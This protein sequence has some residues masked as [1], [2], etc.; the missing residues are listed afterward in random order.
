MFT[1]EFC[2]LFYISKK[3]SKSVFFFIKCFRSILLFFGIVFVSIVSFFSRQSE[4]S[5]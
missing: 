4:A 1:V 5:G 3:E 2:L